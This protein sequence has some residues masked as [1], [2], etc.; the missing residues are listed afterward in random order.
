[1]CEDSTPNFGDKNLAVASQK[2]AASHFLFH[3]GIFT[4]SNMTV[5]LPTLHFSVS[6]IE[7]NIERPPFWHN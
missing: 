7:D 6:P 3:Q 2:H 5:A 4:K 1:M